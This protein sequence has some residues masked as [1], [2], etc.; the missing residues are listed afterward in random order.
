MRR[1]AYLLVLMVLTVPASS[2]VTLEPIGRFTT[3]IFGETAAEIPAYDVSSQRVFVSNSAVNGV[4]VLDVSDPTTPSFLFTIDLADFGDEPTAVAFHGGLGAVAVKSD[5]VTDPGTIVFFDS[6]GM[7]LSTVTVGA[8]PDSATFTPDG[9]KLLVPN[10]G[11]PN[12]EYTVDPEGSLSIIDVTGGGAAIEQDDVR[13]ADFRAFNDRKRQLRNRGVRIFG[14]EVIET[15]GEGGEPE[16][17]VIEGGAS[18]SQDLEPE[19]VTVSGDSS[20]AWVSLQENNALAIVDL[21]T[22]SVRRIVP[23]GFKNHL[24]RGNALDASNR[25][26]AINIA[27]W[28]ALGMYQP[29]WI[30]AYEVDGRTFLVTAN[31]GDAR[32]FDGFSEEERVNDLTLGGSLGVIPNL[33]DDENLGRLKIT[34]SPPRGKRE[35]VGPEGE[36]VFLKLYSYG[37]RSFSIR[38]A[39]GNL[40][41]DS[42]DEFERITAERLGDFPDPGD[43]NSNNDGQ[44]SGDSRSDD[45]GPEPE[46]VTV[47]QVGGRTLAFIGLER[48]GGIMIYDVSN[49]V[50]PLF[51]D[52]V[53]NRDFTVNFD[54]D[55]CEDCEDDCTGD[56]IADCEDAKEACRLCEECPE[57]EECLEACAECEASAETFGACDEC[58]P[59]ACDAVAECIDDCFEDCVQANCPEAGVA[60]R[61]PGDLA[62]EGLL[63][64]PA[65]ESPEGFGH[66]LVVTYEDSGSTTIY[67]VVETVVSLPI[68][69][70]GDDGPGPGRGRGRG[71]G[72]KG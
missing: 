45:K 70:P 25:D 46:A 50:R 17:T 14:P 31:E 60:G 28:P 53:L 3:G 7:V 36:D 35:D 9:T 37:A 49:P 54:L 56:C 32:D 23:L 29:D 58:D 59:A 48:V 44:P 39:N 51:V 27:N 13:T 43:F 26:D 62:P 42:G 69:G 6:E 18:V 1:S 63:F 21:E 55:D 61:D 8:L 41:F 19:Y 40:V 15:V 2:Q 64:I 71:R 38:D 33:Q 16:F 20:T 68:R 12:D 34:T 66:L 65:G 52:Y 30:T 24:L 11:E 5:P 10:E 72:D 47:G 22:A 67:E 4:D 57:G